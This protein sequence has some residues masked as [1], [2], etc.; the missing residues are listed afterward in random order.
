MAAAK[1]DPKNRGIREELEKLKQVNAAQ[2]REERNAYGGM[3]ARAAAAEPPPPKP[4]RVTLASRPPGGMFG[5][6]EFSSSAF[7][8]REDE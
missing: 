4:A 7:G 8:S 1:L 5:N 2:K 3:F 6:V